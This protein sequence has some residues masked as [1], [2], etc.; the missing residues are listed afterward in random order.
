MQN[1]ESEKTNPYN[2]NY[3]NYLDTDASTECTGLMYRPSEDGS[4]WEMYHDIFNFYPGHK[5]P[6]EE[7]SE[8]EP[9]T[10]HQE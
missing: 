8:T 4:Q 6:D 9:Q 10:E 2:I 5:S 7:L 1:T 3:D